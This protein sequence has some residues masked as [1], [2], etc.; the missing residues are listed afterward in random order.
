MAYG[1]RRA[2]G[3]WNQLMERL[4]KEYYGGLGQGVADISQSLWE[5]QLPIFESM[6]E[7]YYG[8][9]AGLGQIVPGQGGSTAAQAGLGDLMS[10]YMADITGTALSA[11]QMP[12]AAR[13]GQAWTPAQ[14]G[15]Q[16]HNVRMGQAEYQARLAEG[17][18]GGVGFGLGAGGGGKKGGG[19]CCFI[20]IEA[21]NGILDRIARR[22]RDEYG[23]EDQR[24]GYKLIA[25][26]LVPLMK[27]RTIIKSLV[28]W[29]MVRPLIW[30]GKA[31]YGENRWGY[32]FWPVARGWLKLFE[33]RGR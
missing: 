31:F 16:M 33:I 17:I 6:I 28:K 21:D 30:W 13:F 29:T 19:G 9:A 15:S 4:S 5:Q 27:K 2:A 11:Y 18:G 10:E 3:Y 8:G 12:W 7:D 26:W 22:Y 32:I 25:A 24:I 20:F 14:I 1:V 23:T